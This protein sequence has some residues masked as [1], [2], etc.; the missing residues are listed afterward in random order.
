MTHKTL[1]EILSEFEEAKKLVG[2]KISYQLSSGG[3]YHE[4]VKSA[5]LFIIGTPDCRTID[6]M[7]GNMEYGSVNVIDFLAQNGYVIALKVCGAIAYTDKIKVSEEEILVNGHIAKREFD[8]WGINTIF[9]PDSTIRRA[10]KFMKDNIGV[11]SMVIFGL[12]FDNKTLDQLIT[13][14]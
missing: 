13:L 12:T 8:G 9:F 1:A 14:S 10:Y 7:W 2:K 11:E 6:S 4:V 3:D 5:T